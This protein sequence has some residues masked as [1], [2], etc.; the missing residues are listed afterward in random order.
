MNTPSIF[1]R[2]VL[3][4]IGALGAIQPTVLV[5]APAAFADDVA[6]GVCSVMV[7]LLPKFANIRRWACVPNW[8]WRSRN[9]ST[10]PPPSCAG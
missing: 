10:T 9:V 3:S 6:D 4:G 5:R 8:S 2:R 1:R 7:K